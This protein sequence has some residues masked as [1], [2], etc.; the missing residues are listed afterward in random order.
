MIIFIR[1]FLFIIPIPI[2][3]DSTDPKVLY[4]MCINHKYEH[5]QLAK[6]FSLHDRH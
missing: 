3:V 5:F 2:S 1:H 6:F 4:Y